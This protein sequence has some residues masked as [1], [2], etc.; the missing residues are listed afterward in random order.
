MINC[1]QPPPPKCWTKTC[2]MMNQV[3]HKKLILCGILHTLEAS[4]H[5]RATLS[6][7]GAWRW[8]A[9]T[10]MCLLPADKMTLL[11][12]NFEVN[13]SK[14]NMYTEKRMLRKW[15][16][17]SIFTKKVHLLTIKSES[18]VAQSCLTL[19]D[20]PGKNTGVGCHFH[21]QEIFPTQGLNPGLLHCR[22]M[23]YHLS[24]QGSINSSY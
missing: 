11:L 22:Q 4:S 10:A 14:H 13:F 19:C 24:H 7:C 17:R 2:P 9:V 15:V 16:A 12:N 1:H 21:L 20:F 8:N 23:L 18:E 5:S 6:L 3:N